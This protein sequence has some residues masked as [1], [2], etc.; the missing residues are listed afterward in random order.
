MTPRVILMVFD[1]LRPD[2]VTPELAPNLSRFADAG[3]RFPMSRAT[4]P[5]ETRVNCAS[6]ATGCRPGRH[7][8]VANVFHAPDAVAGRPLSTGTAEDLEALTAASGGR[9]LGVPSLGERLARAGKSLAVV[10]T[11]TIGSSILLHHEAER[12]GQF[13]WS[14]HGRRYSTTRALPAFERF[15]E[16]PQAAL[17]NTPRIEHAMT[18][19]IDHVLGEISPEVALFWSSDPDS[20]Y[21]YRGLGSA[22]ARASITAADAAFGRLLSWWEAGASEAGTQIICLSDHGHISCREKLSTTDL[23]RAAGFRAGPALDADTDVALAL[24]GPIGVAFRDPADATRVGA[25]LA[26]QP[27]CG[28]VFST[29]KNEIEGEVDGSFAMP[30]SGVDHKRAPHLFFTL[31][32]DDELDANGVA[33]TCYFDSNLPLLG[34]THGGLHPRELNNVLIAGGD[35]FRERYGSPFA[36]GI[37]DVVPTV[38]HLLDLPP[39]DIDGRVLIEAMSRGE[40]PG[41]GKRLIHEVGNGSFRRRLDRQRTGATYYLDGG[42][43]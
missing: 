31:A 38:L 2:M 11:G 41:E 43:A 10:S 37:I 21:H 20:T 8:I 1:G 35:A 32:D 14:S 25:W 27:W 13:R 24:S 22:D 15:G 9:M 30:L 6:L 29:A 23:F 19:F 42:Y 3:S 33:G 16:P 17:P 39:A 12:L 5:T 36:A 4:F 34:G 28:L 40:T 26:E 7:G 18:I